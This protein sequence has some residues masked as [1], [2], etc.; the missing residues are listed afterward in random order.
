MDQAGIFPQLSSVQSCKNRLH[1]P[2]GGAGRPPRQCPRGGGGE[3]WR[4]REA[5]CRALGDKALL[6]TRSLKDVLN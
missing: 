3:G 4:G 6:L 5:H 1:V 2:L